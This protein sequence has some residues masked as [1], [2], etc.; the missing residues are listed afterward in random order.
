MSVPFTL[1]RVPERV[2]VPAEVRVPERVRVPLAHRTL[3]PTRVCGPNEN[4]VARSVVGAA[5][6]VGYLHVRR[7]LHPSRL[8]LLLGPCPKG[9]GVR[10]LSRRC[11]CGRYSF[12][13]VIYVFVGV[14][15]PAVCHTSHVVERRHVAR[16]SLRVDR[17]GISGEG[18][19]THP[20]D[21]PRLLSFLRAVFSVPCLFAAYLR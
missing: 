20:R 10:F 11:R 7:L 14:P 3:R 6:H 18:G 9:F 17:P 15:I 16:L 4:Q 13:W 1:G 2:R 5:L 8:A 21:A 12:M 19:R